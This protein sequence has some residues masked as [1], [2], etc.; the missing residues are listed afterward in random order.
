[1]FLIKRKIDRNKTNTIS[2]QEFRA[3]LESHFS[4]ELSDL[5]FEEFFKTIPKD[6]MSR[7]KYLEFMTKFD[8]DSTASLYDSQSVVSEEFQPKQARKREYEPILEENEENESPRVNGYHQRERDIK[9][10]KN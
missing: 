4:I 7:I 3:A 5:E 1:M 2:K 10:V 9:Q 8:T 6:N